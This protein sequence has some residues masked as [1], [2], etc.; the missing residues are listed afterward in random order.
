MATLRDATS[1]ARQ[2]GELKRRR[3]WHRIVVNVA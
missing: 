3:W 2:N 1:S